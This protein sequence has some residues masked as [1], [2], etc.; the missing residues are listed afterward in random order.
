MAT[1]RSTEVAIAEGDLDAP[2]LHDSVGPRDNSIEKHDRSEE[3][4]VAHQGQDQPDE[5]D[6]DLYG[7]GVEFPTDQE[8]STLRRVAD[9]MPLGAFA[10][11][12]VELCERFAFYGEP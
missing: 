6:V 9:K 12:T 11:V 8:I 3:A 4:S 2:V 10:I 1:A 7:E 5:Q